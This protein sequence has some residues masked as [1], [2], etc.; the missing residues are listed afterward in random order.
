M[1]SS[2]CLGCKKSFIGCHSKCLEYI[3]FRQKLDVENDEMKRKKKLDGLVKFSDIPYAQ[4]RKKT[5]IQRK[6]Y[7]SRPERPSQKD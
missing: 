7:H 3:D 4:R 5:E 1:R 6:A 2:P